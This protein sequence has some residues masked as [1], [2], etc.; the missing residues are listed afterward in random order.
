MT[1]V[2]YEL[3][4]HGRKRAAQRAISDIVLDVLLECGEMEEQK[5]GTSL[6]ELNR[7]ERKAL[8]KSLKQLLRALTNDT[9]PFAV[10]GESGRVIT[11]G[12]KYNNNTKTGA[13]RH[14]THQPQ[15]FG[16]S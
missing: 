12:H 14:G 11:V 5:G 16:T 8:I 13:K 3:T 4:E 10:M 2:N 6:I 9:P 7:R 1:N 15:L